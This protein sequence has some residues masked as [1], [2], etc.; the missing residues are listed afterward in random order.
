ME[1]GSDKAVVEAS[2]TQNEKIAEEETKKLDESEDRLPL[3]FRQN[4]ARVR[5]VWWWALGAVVLGIPVALGATILKNTLTGSIHFLELFVWLEVVWAGF[6]LSYFVAWA[7]GSAANKITEI[8]A[9][10]I[11][12]WDDFFNDL[13]LPMTLIYWTIVI[14]ATIPVICDLNDGDCSSSWEP[15]LRKI[16]LATLVVAASK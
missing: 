15:L 6:W 10:D 4:I 13:R 9:L 7:I 2:E 5:F 1:S 16:A 3:T 8:E 11:G 12:D 14:W